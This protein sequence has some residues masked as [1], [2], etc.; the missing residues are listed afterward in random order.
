M[1]VKFKQADSEK[2][3]SIAMK[4]IVGRDILLYYPNFSERFII[5][6]DAIKTQL[7]EVIS[8]NGKPIVFCSR[9]LTPSQIN[10]TTTERELLS[11]VETLK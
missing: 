7:G 5:H 10:Y 4:K 9:K 6:T 1:E 3:T 8:Q 2:N 11:K